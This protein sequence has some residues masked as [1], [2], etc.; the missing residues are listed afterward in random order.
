MYSGKIAVPPGG[1]GI[2]VNYNLEVLK[3]LQLYAIKDPQMYP[4]YIS[5]KKQHEW[6]KDKGHIFL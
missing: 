5:Y 2:G 1:G 4:P 6:T 3:W